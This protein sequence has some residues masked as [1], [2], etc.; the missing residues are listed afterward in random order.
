VAE[1]GFFPGMILY[2]T[3]WF[4]RA[5]RAQAVAWFMTATSVSGVVGSPLSGA[6]LQM[7][8][9]GG[10]AGWQWLF[11]IEGLPAILLGVVV[12]VYLT[13]RPEQAT[14]LHEDERNWLVANTHADESERA[15]QHGTSL[16]AALK[17]PAVWLFA[18]LY[19]TLVIGFYGVGFWMPKIIKASGDL[20]DF[21]V[22]W[23][24]AVPNLV[25]V[26]AM[27]G[28]GTSSDRTGERRWHVALSALVGASGLVLTT[29]SLHSTVMVVASLSLALAGLRSTL[30]PFWAM[31]TS[32][33]AGT[34]AAGGIAFINSVGNL[35]GGVGPTVYGELRDRLDSH[36]PGLWFLAGTL[37]LA[38]G[39]A[40][41]IRGQVRSAK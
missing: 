36:V 7:Q 25:S 32:V 26:F 6:L 41:A 24:A 16:A 9:I 10:L 27:I 3:Y 34:A 31:P 22:G 11:L 15:A 38:A 33:L 5:Q 17:T 8:G 21:E 13:D 1:A 19:F 30:G 39:V 28:V 29:L 37:C 20:T 14:W 40:I 18:L 2:L 4:P 23:W 12:L 35:G